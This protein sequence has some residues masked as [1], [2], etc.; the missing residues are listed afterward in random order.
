MNAVG[1]GFG[2][3]FLFLFIVVEG[4]YG[5]PTGSEEERGTGLQGGIVMLFPTGMPKGMGGIDIG[6]MPSPGGK[7]PGGII[8]GFIEPMLGGITAEK[9]KGII[10]GIVDGEGGTVFVGF[11][12]VLGGLRGRLLGGRV[13]GRYPKMIIGGVL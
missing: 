1:F 12:K 9:G 10:P 13:P 8:M 4:A 6:G 5:R 3:L 2:D 7:S 11:G